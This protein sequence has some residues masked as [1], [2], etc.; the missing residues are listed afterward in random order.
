MAILTHLQVD[1]QGVGANLHDHLQ[2]RGVFRLKDGTVSLNALANSWIGRVKM[3]TQHRS[4]LLLLVMT[5]PPAHFSE[6]HHIRMLHRL[7]VLAESVGSVV[8]GSITAWNVRTVG[9]LRRYPRLAVPCAASQP[10]QLQPTTALV[11]G[12][13]NVRLQLAAHL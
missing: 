11:S 12:H 8:D 13:D 5:M 4:L 1:L 3:G 6:L 2:I 7:A 10:R 9:C